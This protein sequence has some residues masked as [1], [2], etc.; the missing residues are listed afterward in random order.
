MRVIEAYLHAQV[1][2]AVEKESWW[3]GVTEEGKGRQED[4]GKT[5]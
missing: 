1:N 4:K 2:D 5:G 3:Q